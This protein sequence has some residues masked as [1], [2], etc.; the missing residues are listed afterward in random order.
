[1]PNKSILSHAVVG[2]DTCVDGY[3]ET[4]LM[5]FIGGKVIGG[6]VSL[7]HTNRKSA[8]IRQLYV[9]PAFRRQGIASILLR[10]CREIARTSGCQTIGLV[11]AEGN[12]EARRLYEKEGFSL[13]YQYDDNEILMVLS[14]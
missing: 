11:V 1:M 7:Q 10:E 9:A 5:L 4:K 3:E 8:N 13:A 2:I 14:L 6:F 12:K